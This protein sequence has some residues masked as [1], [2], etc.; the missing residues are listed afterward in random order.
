MP[1]TDSDRAL[2][3]SDL[4]THPNCAHQTST[5]SSYSFSSSGG[6]AVTE[7][8]TVLRRCKDSSENGVVIDRVDNKEGDEVGTA[9]KDITSEVEKAFGGALLSGFKVFGVG[10]KG[11]G[12]VEEKP[13][14]RFRYKADT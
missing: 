10:D 4:K 13:K 1:L 9:V 5:S 8:V 3:Q 12:G 11:V 14:R 7:R 6:S 2:L